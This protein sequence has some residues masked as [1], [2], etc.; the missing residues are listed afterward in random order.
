MKTVVVGSKNPIKTEATKEAFALM[1][2]NMVFD[3]IQLEVVSGVNE[4]PF[5]NEETKQGA[6][7]R[8]LHAKELSGVGDYF[9]GLEGGIEEIDGALWVIAWMCV[10]DPRGKMGHGRTSSFLLPK[11]VSELV[12]SGE[13]LGKATDIAFQKV[14][15]KHSG[16]TVAAL[17]NDAITRADFYRDAIAFALIPFLK[18]ELY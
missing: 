9:V 6:T 7:N 10:I 11:V 1:F 3:F 8:A 2:P 13:E 12:C 18:P 16:G 17:T 15:S 4:Q 5:G 14:N